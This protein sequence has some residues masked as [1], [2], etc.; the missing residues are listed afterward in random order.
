MRIAPLIIIFTIVFASFTSAAMDPRLK[1]CLQRGYEIESASTPPYNKNCVFP[2]GNKCPLEDFNTGLCGEE[3][4]TEDYCVKKGGPVWD[5]DKCCEGT[6]A[7]II[8]GFM[9]QKTCQS[10][11]IFEIGYNQIRYNITLWFFTGL[12]IILIL[13]VFLGRLIYCI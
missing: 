1:E 5:A 3:Y 9:G 6:T 10:I 13:L 7:Y 12:I 4:K 2:D 11:S 8:P